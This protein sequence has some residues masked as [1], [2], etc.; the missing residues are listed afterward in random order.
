MSNTNQ[1]TYSVVVDGHWSVGGVVHNHS[2]GRTCTLRHCRRGSVP[3]VDDS[4][5]C[6]TEPELLTEW[7]E[8]VPERE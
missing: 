8:D 1:D 2:G 7:L 6:A 3:S 4:E 5:P